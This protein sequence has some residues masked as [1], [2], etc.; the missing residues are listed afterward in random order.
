MPLTTPEN[1]LMTLTVEAFVSE[2]TWGVT[3]TETDR[4]STY[5]GV[6]VSHGQLPKVSLPAAPAPLGKELS[7]CLGAVFH[8]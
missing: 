5:L 3:E 8:S 7:S 4:W 1:M 2:T 6:G